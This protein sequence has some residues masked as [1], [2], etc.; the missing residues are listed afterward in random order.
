SDNPDKAIISLKN[1]RETSYKVY[2]SVQNELVAAYNDLRDREFTR[3]YPNESMTF[4]EANKKYSDPRTSP[5]E[6]ERLDPMLDKIKLM[7]PQKL[8]EAEPSKTN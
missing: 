4:V 8:S 7:Y 6:K 5:E 1:D 2:I 3:L